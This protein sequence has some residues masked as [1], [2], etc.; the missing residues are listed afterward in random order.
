MGTQK[1]PPGAEELGCD[2]RKKGSDTWQA[3]D[4]HVIFRDLCETAGGTP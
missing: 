3:N 1:G 4:R 2:V